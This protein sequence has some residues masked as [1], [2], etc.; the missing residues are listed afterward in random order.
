MKEFSISPHATTEDHTLN[1]FTFAIDSCIEA[2]TKEDIS[3]TEMVEIEVATE[4]FEGF[5][6]KFIFD[7]KSIR[8]STVLWDLRV[9]VFRT[10]LVSRS[11]L[12]FWASSGGG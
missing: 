3:R 6:N 4:A 1:I 11:T 2:R 10:S 12:M 9:E 8:G 5:K 7:W